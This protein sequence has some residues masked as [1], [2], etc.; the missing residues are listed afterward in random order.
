MSRNAAFVTLLTKTAYLPGTL[1][2]HQS[3]LDVESKYPFVVMVTP[4]VAERD[5][6]ILR[7][8]GIT[9]RDIDSLV[10]EE[11]RHVVANHD[12]RFRDTWTK[13]RYVAQ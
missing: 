2:L 5:R 4:T 11:G 3:L 13:L 6:E 7:K 8:R 10:P 1:V 9:L 12:M